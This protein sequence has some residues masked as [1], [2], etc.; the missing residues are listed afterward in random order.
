MMTQDH[1]RELRRCLNL[2]GRAIVSFL[3]F[4]LRQVTAF[5][6]AGRAATGR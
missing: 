3:L 2:S 5:G 1:A 4:K 6:A